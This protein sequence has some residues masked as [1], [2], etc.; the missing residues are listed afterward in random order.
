MGT[1]GLA[2][3]K[4]GML[5]TTHYGNK[6]IYGFDIT[7]LQASSTVSPTVTL[8]LQANVYDIAIFNGRMFATLNQKQRLVELNPKDGS[9]LK[10]YTQTGGADFSGA[11][12]FSVSRSTLFVANPKTKTVTA[13]PVPEN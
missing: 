13:I 1:Y 7:A 2:M 10:D 12:K 6:A 3:D 11:E 5:Y 4:G 9:I 8:K